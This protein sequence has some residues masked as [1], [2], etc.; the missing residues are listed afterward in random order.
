MSYNS[1][2]NHLSTYIRHKSKNWLTSHKWQFKEMMGDKK[3]G[4]LSNFS[5]LSRQ[6]CAFFRKLHLRPVHGAPYVLASYT[7]PP[8]RKYYIPTTHTHSLTPLRIRRALDEFIRWGWKSL[9]LNHLRR[10]L[11]M[12][13]VRG[14][15]C[16][17]KRLAPQKTIRI[18]CNFWYVCVVRRRRLFF[19]YPWVQDLYS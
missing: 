19:Q 5:E 4:G 14:C 2:S 12:Y 7:H 10:K 1:H 16:E 9:I 3:L 13:M 15:T 8:L 17:S 11:E 18:K 6:L